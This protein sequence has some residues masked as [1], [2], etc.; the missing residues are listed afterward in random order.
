M[1]SIISVPV[2]TPRSTSTSRKRKNPPASTPPSTPKRVMNTAD[3]LAHVGNSVLDFSCR[4]ESSTEKLIGALMMQVPS[5]E[6]LHA[7]GCKGGHVADIT[8]AD[9]ILTTP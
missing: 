2:K 6:L 9:T 5:G 1:E 4:F 3:A 7:L 8:S